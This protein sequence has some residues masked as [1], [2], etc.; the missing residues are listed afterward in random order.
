[1]RMCEA[2]LALNRT[3]DGMPR[4]LD[5]PRA[6]ER[7]S[8][9]TPR[10]FHAGAGM[11]R[12]PPIRTCDGIASHPESASC[13]QAIIRWHAKGD[14]VRMCEACLA[15]N[16]TC[17]GM[18]RTLDKPRA[19]ERSS[20]GTPRRFHAGAGMN[21]APPIRTCDGIASHPES[22]SCAQ[23]IIRWHAKGDAVR[24]CEACLALNRT[25]DGIASHP[26]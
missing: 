14:A 21:R 6:P 16:R 24:M 23:A 26:R 4:T 20:Y 8:Y 1:M 13:A 3:C 19:P 22:A 15:L 7:S 9:G 17:D 2:C 25:C 5:K 18:P 12:A 11:N 10:R